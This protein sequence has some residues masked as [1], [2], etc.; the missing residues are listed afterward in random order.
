MVVFKNTSLRTFAYRYR[1]FP[2]LFKPRVSSSHFFE[3]FSRVVFSG[4]FRVYA[5]QPFSLY[6]NAF[7]HVFRAFL[8]FFCLL[9]NTYTLFAC[10][11]LRLLS[12]TFRSTFS[13]NVNASPHVFLAFLCC[14]L[15]HAPPSSVFFFHAPFFF[16]LFV[17]YHTHTHSSLVV[18][19]G[20]FHVFSVQLF[21]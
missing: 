3:P 19:S 16:C 17:Y 6:V 7:P 10:R 20:S 12:R 2:R 5:V 11:F 18:S 13:L 14:I 4:P 9:S 21:V 1:I 15:F 8:T